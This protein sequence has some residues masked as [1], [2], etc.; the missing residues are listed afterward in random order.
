MFHDLLSENVTYVLLARAS[1]SQRCSLS[2]VPPFDVLHG[3]VLYSRFAQRAFPP[4]ILL[5][6]AL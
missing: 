5:I 4:Y 3:W 6:R 1:A 2:W